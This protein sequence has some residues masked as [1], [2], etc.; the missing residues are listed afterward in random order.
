[1]LALLIVGF[2]IN[3]Q[4]HNNAD[5]AFKIANEAKR[6]VFL[7][8]AGSD[9]CAPC[10]EFEKKVLLDAN[11]KHF[12]E[13]SLVILKADF[14]QR[15]KLPRQLQEQNDK[16]ASLYNPKGLFPLLLVIRADGKL[17]STIHYNHQHVEDFITQIKRQ[18][19]PTP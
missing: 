10:I 12:A 19:P 15:E 13:E 17:M 18:L 1:M 14:P 9:W 3:A 5:D 2:G 16:L 8:F 6:P 4:V 11:F 7:I